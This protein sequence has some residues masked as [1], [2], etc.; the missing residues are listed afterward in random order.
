[1]PIA[2]LLGVVQLAAVVAI[3]YWKRW[4]VYLYYT[5]AVVGF[6]SNVLV[7]LP[8]FLWIIWLVSFGLFVFFSANQWNDFE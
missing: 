6:V 7:G 5:L 8:T 1:M 4:G 2:S 3:W